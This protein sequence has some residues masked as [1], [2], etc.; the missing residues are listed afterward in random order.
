MRP[1]EITF[2]ILNPKDGLTRQNLVDINTLLR[3][4]RGNTGMISREMALQTAQ[5]SRVVLARYQEDRIIGMGVLALVHCMSHTHAT[6]HN[7]VVADGFNLHTTT[8]S[9]LEHLVQGMKIVAYIEAG[10]W[11]QDEQG[12]EA[13]LLS[14]HFVKKDKPRYR[15]RFEHGNSETIHAPVV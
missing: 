8:Q 13:I 7:L 1:P 4:Q 15:L 12:L 10:A 11:L 5:H 3:K 6:L 14:M 9:I 2:S